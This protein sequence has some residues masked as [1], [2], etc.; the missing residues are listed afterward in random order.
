MDV[1][2]C[3]V[4]TFLQ[5]WPSVICVELM[6]FAPLCQMER[7][8]VFVN[9]VILRAPLGAWVSLLDEIDISGSLDFRIA[10]L[11]VYSAYFM[12]HRPSPIVRLF[13]HKLDLSSL[14]YGETNPYHSEFLNHSHILNDETKV[15]HCFM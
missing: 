7:K 3:N 12:L 15:F 9:Q 6:R 10:T 1:Y 11:I 14:W 4:D 13:H 8:L 2:C 5:R